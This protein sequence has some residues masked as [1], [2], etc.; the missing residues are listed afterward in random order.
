MSRLP[1]L[2]VFSIPENL[3][4][5][6]WYAVKSVLNFFPQQICCKFLQ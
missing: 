3:I 4:N 5:C 6:P 2:L 1:R